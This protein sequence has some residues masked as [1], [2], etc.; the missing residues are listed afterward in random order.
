LITESPKGLV[1]QFFGNNAQSYEKVVNLATF[2]RDSHWK[3]EMIKRIS[4]CD[5][6]LDLA[7]GTGIL[8]FQI[9]EK[10]PDAKITGVDLTEGYLK[11]AKDKLKPCHKIS[12]LLY[13]AEKITLDD[14]FDCIT[15][16]YIPKY[17]NPQILIERCLC[18]L[19]AGGKIILHDFVNPKNKV[20]RS[21]WNLYFVM[22]NMVGF[23][24]PNWKETFKNLPQLIRSI[25]WVDMYKG[26][27]ERKGLNVEIKY[28][29]LGTSVI[30][31]GTKKV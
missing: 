18:H 23:F 17:C 22:L 3:E 6:I 2:G 8:T 27:M 12:F 25:N 26:A 16:S 4:R 10:F 13:D 28:L 24:V 29:T 5:S 1:K 31:T 20:I 30:L 14:T 15:S 19:N 21:L 11:I 7:C 9:A